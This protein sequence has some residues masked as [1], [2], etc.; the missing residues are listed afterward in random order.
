[1]TNLPFVTTLRYLTLRAVSI[2]WMSG[3]TFDVLERCTI[4][5][6]LRHHIP[7]IFR[8]ALP[9][10][11]H[12][13]FQGYPLDKLDGVSA[14]K[15]I[16]LSV[17]SSGSFNRRGARQLVWFSSQILGERR[18][19][20]QILHIGIEATSRAWINALTSM[21]HLEELVISNAR[22]SLR[23]KVLQSLI[24]PPVHGS[25]TG[26]TSTFQQWDAPLC[27]SLKRFG[28]K[29]H[30]W[31]RGNEH[32]D[33]HRDFFSIISSR[34]RSNYPLHSFSVWTKSDQKN[35]F[36][37]ISRSGDRVSV[38]AVNGGLHGKGYVS[39][40]SDGVWPF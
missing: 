7:P 14:H 28:L 10:C 33:L 39:I 13:T 2:Q 21:L 31:L 19:A 35:P 12:L 17:T 27:P 24:A 11:K 6:P 20:P 25:S 5:F 23:A 36:E 3:R 15:L 32:F 29:Y 4:N 37:L 30:R 1:V 22:P 26:I 18:F 9:N 8:T 34:H 38:L 16:D 40:D